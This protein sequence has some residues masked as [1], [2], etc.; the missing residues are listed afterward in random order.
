MQKNKKPRY[1]DNITKIETLKAKYK[2]LAKQ[3]HPDLNQNLH[4]A[5][6]LF[7][8]MDEQYQSRLYKLSMKQHNKEQE[9]SASQENNDDSYE[10]I[11]E[12]QT[13]SSFLQNLAKGVKE[14]DVKVRI[15]VGNFSF[16]WKNK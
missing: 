16:R 8:E 11:E 5:K 9:Q 13:H 14:K 12:E 7:Q 6:E 4:N 3:M 1:F 2:K 15:D 10:S